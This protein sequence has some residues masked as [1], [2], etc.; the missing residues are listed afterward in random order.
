M[1]NATVCTIGDEILIG[2]VLDTNS[3]KLALALEEAGIKVSR[4]ISIAD[5]ADEIAT[6]LLSEASRSGIIITTG[7]LGPTKDDITKPVLA[8]LSGSRG[9]VEHSGQLE[10]VHRILKSRGLDVLPVNLAQAQV[11]DKAEVI[12]NK[13]GTA[14]IMIFRNLPGGATLYALPGVPHEAVGAIPDI[15]ADI[16]AHQPLSDILHRN[17]MVYG[18]AESAL[19]EKIA[20]WEDALPAQMHLAYLPNTLTGIR[21]RLSCYAGDAQEQRPIMEEQL[22]NLREILG[23]LV[24]AETDSTL[25]ESIG[26]LLKDKGKTLS[27][28]ESCTG[29]EIAHLITSVPGSSAYFLGSVTSYAVSVKETVLGVPS[30]IIER[31]GVVSS[32]VAAAMAEGVRRLTGSDYAVATTGL[33]GPAGDERNPVG[34]VWIGVSGPAGTRTVSYCYKNDRKRNIERFAASALNFLRLDLENCI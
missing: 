14:P 1:V 27:A 18:I 17:L 32:E 28:A 13:L 2:Q 6:T 24:Y 12:V 7:G 29:G 16:R 5:N 3:Q 26:K 30:E 22:K 11:P 8:R 21:L 33:A 4:M 25:E 19:S 31:C 34:T 10:M 15:M 20:A 23:T 9:Y